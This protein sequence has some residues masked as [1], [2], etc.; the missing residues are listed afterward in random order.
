MED[1]GRILSV[2]EILAAPDIEER[3]VDVPEWGGAVK[4][5]GFTKAQ[6]QQFRK[7]ATVNGEVDD[8]RI[9]VLMFIHGVTEPQFT[10]DRYEQLR[11]KSAGAI[12]KV[13]AAILEVSGMSARS[14][15]EAKRSFREGSEQA[16]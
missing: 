13:L 12:D 3:T 7:E 1:R 15:R 5:R 9:E 2:D 14:F 16:V 4:V 11:S 10:A 8:D 6:Q